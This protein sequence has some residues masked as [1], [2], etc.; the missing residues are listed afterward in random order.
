MNQYNFNVLSPLEFEEFAKDILSAVHN[1][2][3]Q[4]YSEGKDGGIDMR[5][6][7]KE[8]TDET[9]IQCKRYKTTTALTSNLL[10]KERPKLNKLKPKKYILVLSLD[11]SVK[12]VDKLVKAFKPYIKSP[13]DIIMPKQLNS[14]LAKNPQVEKRHFKLWLTSSNVLDTIIHSSID[15]YSALTKQNIEDSATLFVP[16][17]NMQ[18]A[19]DKLRDNGFI[20]ITG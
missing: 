18:E 1:V 14:Y 3:Y 16:L 11:L 7:A 8:H 6:I 10:H 2:E 19:I 5:Y 15:N 17:P 9:I 12:R 4:T 20:I 13:H